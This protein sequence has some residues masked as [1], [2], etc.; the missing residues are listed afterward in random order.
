MPSDSPVVAFLA[1]RRA[2]GTERAFID[3]A[4]NLVFADAKFASR[5]GDS[6]S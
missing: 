2:V 3:P 6:E 4:D 1:I 5:F